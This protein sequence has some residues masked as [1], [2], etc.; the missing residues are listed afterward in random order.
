VIADG[1]FRGSASL[2]FNERKVIITSMLLGVDSSPVAVGRGILG[3]VPIG[4]D[5]QIDKYEYENPNRQVWFIDQAQAGN[6][7]VHEG[8]RSDAEQNFEQCAGVPVGQEREKSLT[9]AALRLIIRLRPVMNL[10]L[11]HASI[12]ALS[13]TLGRKKAA[14]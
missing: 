6:D 7:V 3:Y 11:C 5:S 2:I 12:I 9:P 14:R 13:Q 8:D 10:W 1:I 4:A